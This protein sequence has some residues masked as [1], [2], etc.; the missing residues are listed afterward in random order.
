MPA[1]A[2]A[3]KHLGFNYNYVS[4]NASVE[5][6]ATM[7]NVQLSEKQ[8]TYI[9]LALKVYKEKL[10]DDEEDPGPSMADSLFVADLASKLET[11][12]FNK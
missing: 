1:T 10:E 12:Y 8:L 11:K 5:N 7:I 4:T 6:G 3:N 9:V 2:L